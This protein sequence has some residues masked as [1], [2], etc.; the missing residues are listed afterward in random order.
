MAFPYEKNSAGVAGIACVL[1][2]SIMENV[3][4]AFTALSV[5]LNSH[6]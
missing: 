4:R 1:S 6:L 3:G 2:G 5:L